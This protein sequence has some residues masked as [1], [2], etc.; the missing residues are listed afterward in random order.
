MK[1]LFVLENYHPFIGGAEVLFK[2]LCEGLVAAGHNVTVLTSRLPGTAKT[3]V[4]GGVTIRR[5]STPAK[6]YRYWF[7]FLAIVP[8]IGLAAK[9]DIVQTTTYNGA[10]PAWLAARLT[11]KKCFLTVLEIIGPR[12]KDMTGMTWFTVWL[13]R[14][15]ENVIVSL[16]FDRYV[17]ISQFTAGC[18]RQQGR[19]TN[20]IRVIYTGV[21][22]G[23]FNPGKADKAAVRA[24]LGLKDEF[25]YLYYGRPGI[26][27]GADYLVQAAPL[28]AAGIP[29]SKLVMILAREP[30]EGYR[31]VQGLIKQLKLENHITVLDPVPRKEL[32]EYLASADCIVVPSLTEGFGLSAAEACAMDRPVVISNT[33]SLPEVVGGK[34]CLVRPADPSDIARGVLDTYG[35]RCITAAKKLFPWSDC[36]N[37]YLLMYNELLNRD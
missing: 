7:T 14:F 5:I 32:P 8:A 30:A 15:L 13:H 34:Y 22:Y 10:F 36:I 29:S 25:V 28:I 23:L 12:W 20:K 37:G 16:P 24:R 31:T 4:D 2:N 21:D 1:L 17:A 19:P 26:S 27:K 3:Q 33:S 6:G 18:V 35:G 9:S 11:G